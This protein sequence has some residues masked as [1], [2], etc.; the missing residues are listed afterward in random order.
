MVFIKFKL[1][2]HTIN[3]RYVATQIF[4]DSC[5][6]VRFSI[7]SNP[8]SNYFLCNICVMPISVLLLDDGGMGHHHVPVEGLSSSSDPGGYASKG[9]LLIRRR[10]DKGEIK[11]NQQVREDSSV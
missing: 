9:C 3:I 5:M 1:N 2:I 6:L 7:H 10:K 11:N 8:C 4:I